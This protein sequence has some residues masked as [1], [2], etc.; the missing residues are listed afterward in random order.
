ME[1]RAYE[2]WWRRKRPQ[3]TEREIQELIAL[4]NAAE[5]SPRITV[6][7]PISVRGLLRTTLGKVLGLPAA[8]L[9]SMPTNT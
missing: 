6:V 2:Q 1:Q 7:E 9:R 4:M 5:R 8:I 3:L